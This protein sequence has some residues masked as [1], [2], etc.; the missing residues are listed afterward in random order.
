MN[1]LKYIRSLKAWLKKDDLLEDI[2]I[3]IAELEKTTLPLYHDA[4]KLP[5]TLISKANKDIIATLQRNMKL[6]GKG[7][8]PVL[9]TIKD[10]LTAT[11][12]VAKIIETLADDLLGGD[13]I[14][15]GLAAKKAILVRAADHLGF[16]SRYSVDLLNVLYANEIAATADV[17]ISAQTVKFIKEKAAIYCTL[18]AAYGVNGEEFTKAFDAIPDII[19]NDRNASAVDASYS[20]N[21]IDPLLGSLQ[22]NFMYSP[23]YHIRLQIAEYQAQRYKAAKEKKKALELRLLYLKTLADGRSDPKIEQEIA[24]QQNRVEALEYKLSKMEENV[25]GL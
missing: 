23:I 1:L 17:A 24:Y 8:N 4:D 16:I 18:L 21:K 2:G 22:T 20:G 11:L 9:A 19:I 6:T 10:R 14:A 15:D 7:K 12:A 5:D 25:G 3:T 13:I